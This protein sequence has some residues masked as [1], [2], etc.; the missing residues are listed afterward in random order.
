MENVKY[1]RSLEDGGYKISEN[2]KNYGGNV[3]LKIY[4]IFSKILS[5]LHK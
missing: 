5:F 4:Y 3:F 1:K 2:L